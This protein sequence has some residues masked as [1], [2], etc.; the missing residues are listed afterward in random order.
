[1]D[2]T[3][4]HYA[5]MTGNGLKAVIEGCDQFF[6]ILCGMKPMFGM[7]LPILEGTSRAMPMY[8]RAGSTVTIVRAVKDSML[9][10]IIKVVVA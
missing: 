9:K 3:L 4:D 1:L 8:G 10:R 6:P 2:K 7:T 5:V